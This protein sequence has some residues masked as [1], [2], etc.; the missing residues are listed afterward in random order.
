MESERPD[1]HKCKYLGLCLL[2]CGF[3]NGFQ[4]GSWFDCRRRCVGHGHATGGAACARRQ[5]VPVMAR[6]VPKG[7]PDASEGSTPCPLAATVSREKGDSHSVTIG[8]ISLRQTIH[9]KH[10]LPPWYKEISL[11][12]WPVRLRVAAF[13]ACCTVS[14]LPLTN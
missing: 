4:S 5:P 6:P 9:L 2:C 8:G 13:N 3:C 7:D 11:F 14:S 10:S 12:S 1:F